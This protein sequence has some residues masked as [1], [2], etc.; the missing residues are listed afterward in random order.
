[1][2]QPDLG[3]HA[4]SV[5]SCSKHI[6]LDSK[7]VFWEAECTR[8]KS[9]AIFKAEGQLENFWDTAEVWETTVPADRVSLPRSSSSVL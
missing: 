4:E 8:D 6:H 2:M 3:L 1:M 9:H 7:C 5:I